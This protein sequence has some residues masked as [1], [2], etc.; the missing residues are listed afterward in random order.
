MKN[1]KILQPGYIWWLCIIIL[2][3]I[4]QWLAADKIR[5][6][7]WYTHRF[8]QN[9]AMFFRI[10]F[11]WIPFSIGDILYLLAGVWLLY[12]IVKNIARVIKRGF[13][14]YIFFPK[15][16][17]AIFIG[18]S[19]YV[20]FNIFWGLNYNRKGIAYQLDLKNERYDTTDLY[21]V[22]AHLI[23][24]ANLSKQV[25][26]HNKETYPQNKELF[27]RAVMCFKEAQQQF[28]YLKYDQPSVKSSMF[29]W[30]GNYLGFTGYYNPFT[31]EAQVNTGVPAFLQPYITAHEIGHQAG[32]GK[33]DEASFVG[34]LAAVNSTDTLFHYSAYLDL[35][36][37][38]N[39]EVYFIDSARSKK[40][41]SMLAQPVQNDIDEWRRFSMEHRSFLEPAI[42]WAYGHFLK[43]NQQPTGMRSYNE[44]IS[45][46]IS[47]YKKYGTI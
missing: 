34:Y 20:A 11:G 40:Y 7:E 17:R 15:L 26:A 36:M 27:R 10:L 12:K 2:I 42:T 22:T 32:Y 25:L 41:F 39:R 43:L 46:L 45:M 47:Y 5:V 28:P 21:M 4:I 19:I 31:G 14:S 44:V 8:Y 9:I 16:F 6:E 3:I 35:F 18:L 29:G 24:K 30:L 37:Y 1:R 38:A 33:E 23:N 13:N